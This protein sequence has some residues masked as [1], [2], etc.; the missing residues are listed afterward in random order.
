MKEGVEITGHDLV[1]LGVE[2]G[3]EFARAL[4]FARSELARGLGWEEVSRKVVDKFI[5]PRVELLS[6]G[7]EKSV[8]VAAA[9]SSEEEE[10][11][12]SVS[13]A[14][15]KEL[16]RSPVVKS[17]ALMPDTCPSGSGWGEIPVGGV[18]VTGNEVI[19]AAHSADV[20][21]GM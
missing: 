14:R 11:N 9:P 16:T 1:G 6:L 13:L 20:N 4:S 10:N 8:S 18:V 19:P 12:V 7:A 3:P 5:H 2:P 17:A 15:I 21:C